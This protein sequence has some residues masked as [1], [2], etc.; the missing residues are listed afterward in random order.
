MKGL[1]NLKE[2]Q[3]INR[4]LFGISIYLLLRW[5]GKKGIENT[6]INHS[7]RKYVQVTAKKYRHRAL[8]G[9]GI[10]TMV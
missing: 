2:K 1:Y 5:N 9:S 6:C 7:P 3:S 8:T 4:G 10:K